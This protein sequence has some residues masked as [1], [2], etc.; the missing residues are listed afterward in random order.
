MVAS[1]ETKPVTVGLLSRTV[2][3]ATDSRGEVLRIPPEAEDSVC[4]AL[5][6]S[7]SGTQYQ[8][9]CAMTFLPRHPALAYCRSMIFSENRSGITRDATPQ[10]HRDRGF[11]KDPVRA[12][13]A[14]YRAKP[15]LPVQ[16]SRR[17]NGACS[18]LSVK[19]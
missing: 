15:V 3:G 12:R 7:G 8:T 17:S 19:L 4:R 6:A 14:Y 9:S 13:R 18:I 10:I 5:R 2:G 11:G 16:L 1:V